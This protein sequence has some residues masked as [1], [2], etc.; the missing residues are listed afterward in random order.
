MKGQMET[1][2]PGWLPKARIAQE[3]TAGQRDIDSQ[4]LTIFDIPRLAGSK[5]N[6]W[7]MV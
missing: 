4:N 5:Q 6:A 3:R 2:Q 1:E 7:E